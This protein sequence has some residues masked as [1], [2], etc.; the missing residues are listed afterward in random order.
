MLTTDQRELV[1]NLAPRVF[2]NDNERHVGLVTGIVGCGHAAE[3]T[4]LPALSG[5]E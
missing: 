4:G 5:V 1:Q 2:Q 3:F